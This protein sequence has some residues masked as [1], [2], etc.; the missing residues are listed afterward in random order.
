[1]PI[2]CAKC[3]RIIAEQLGEEYISRKRGRVMI[4]PASGVVVCE[5]CGT[6]NI[7]GGQDGYELNDF[8]ERYPITVASLRKICQIACEFVS[9][10]QMTPEQIEKYFFEDAEHTVP[11]MIGGLNNEKDC[12]SSLPEMWSDY[13]N[14]SEK[15]RIGLPGVRSSD[16]N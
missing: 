2:R 13:A 11:R 10:T 14:Q 7:M 16:G 15:Q 1:M 9:Y 4:A 12:G 6:R 8:A 5:N 3:G